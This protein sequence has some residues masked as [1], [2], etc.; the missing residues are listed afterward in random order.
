MGC[1][2]GL[3]VVHGTSPLCRGER[4]G[5]GAKCLW[6]SAAGIL[7]A[8]AAWATPVDA[9]THQPAAV[10]TVETVAGPDFCEG[11]ARV[12]AESGEVR[13]LAVGPAGEIFASTGPV[14]G[15]LVAMV[16]SD[17][18]PSLVR[19]GVPGGA[20]GILASDGTGGFVLAAGGKVEEWAPRGRGVVAGDPLG[21]PGPAS[22]DGGPAAAARFKGVKAVATDES[23]NVYIADA[24][25]D[26]GGAVRVRLVNRSAEPV[27]VY[28]G[29]PH[30]L[31]VAPGHVNTIAGG[32]RDAGGG[33]GGPGLAATLSGDPVTL[34]VAGG[35]LYVAA[36]D[37]RHQPAKSGV[38]VVNL[39]GST[40]VAHGVEVG[41]GAVQ[42]VAG[43]GAVGYGGE[44]GPAGEARLGRLNGIA[45]DASGNLYLADGDHHRVRRVDSA[46]VITTFAGTGSS[47]QGG[48]N[49]NDRSATAARL[50]RPFDVKVGPKERVYI[51]DQGNGQ[52]RYVGPDGIIQAAPGNG[53]GLR[54]RCDPM[55]P[56]PQVGSPASV[57]TDGAGNVYLV[58]DGFPKVLQVDP[59]GTVAPVVGAGSGQPRCQPGDPSC[60]PA[61]GGPVDKVRLN[62]PM[63]VV[64]APGGGLYVLDLGRLRLANL[65]T[66]RL[67]AHGLDVAPGTIATV[68]A[69]DQDP[70]RPPA[71]SAIASGADGSV[72][73][74]DVTGR[75]VRLAASGRAG[76]GPQPAGIDAAPAVE[77]AAAVDP[78]DVVECCQDATALAVDSAGNPYIADVATFRVWYRN[79]GPQPVTVHGQTVAPGALVPVAGSGKRGFGGDNGPAPEAQLEG[80]V[81]LA[82]GPD[83]SLYIAD[84]A[85]HT[86]RKVSSAGLITTVAGTGTTGFNGD[87][88]TGRLTMLASPQDLAFDRCGNLLIADA[89]NNR[90]RRLNLAGS[91]APLGADAGGAA[92]TGGSNLLF[93]M[94]AVAVVAVGLTVA[95]WRRARP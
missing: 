14:A 9:T 67:Q 39:G 1:H 72:F 80:P 41:A 42:T 5:G 89:G 54:W 59:A 38:R 82:V 85:E 62:R 13:A 58:V 34:A 7:T 60:P 19:T 53:V 77:P 16:N 43:G 2:H 95:V 26:A 93:A 17:G 44:R 18:R 94:V 11:P 15:G 37:V 20:A 25:D 3:I 55:A 29:T 46:G 30:E 12:D 31:T 84:A 6:A 36:H 21:Q 71:V 23:G 75:V 91:C 40:V 33:D 49:G 24:L 86:V 47:V 92:R 68:G 64:G 90:L 78:Y 48:Y 28:P 4:A 51:S 79:L 56:A 74:L 83:G 69:A 63:A 61:D 52:V 35:R 45:A 32:G 73:T 10:G 22:G 76:S 87:G 50:D 65:G 88:L 27:T 57:A 81:G 66:G 70:D 8:A